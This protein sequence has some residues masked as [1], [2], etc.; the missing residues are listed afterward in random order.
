MKIK[1]SVNVELKIEKEDCSNDEIK[2][3]NKGDITEIES[4]DSR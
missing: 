4:I 1:W 2:L 3:F